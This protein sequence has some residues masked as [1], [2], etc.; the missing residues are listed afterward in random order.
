MADDP[1]RPLVEEAFDRLLGTLDQPMLVV[2]A[3]RGDERSGCL[4]GFAGQ[5]SIRPARFLVCLSVQNRTYRVAR[6]VDH[7]AVHF[8]PESS[9]DLARLFG[10]HTGDDVDKFA[11]CTWHDGPHGLPILDACDNRFV[12]TVV[13]RLPLG[14]HVGFLLEPDHVHHGADGHQLDLHR[15]KRIDP[16]HP[17]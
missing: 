2:T 9:A 7:L 12:G 10:G 1:P 3:R 17:A 14:D 16:G 15:A 8:V 6:H 5:V 13:E 4:V 11:C